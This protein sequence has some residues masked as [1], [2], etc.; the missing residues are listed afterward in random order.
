MKVKCIPVWT[1]VIW[2]CI[3]VFNDPVRRQSACKTTFYQQPSANTPAVLYFSK[4]SCLYLRWN[5]EISGE[6]LDNCGTQLTTFAANGQTDGKWTTTQVPQETTKEKKVSHWAPD[7][8]C[9]H[10]ARTQIQWASCLWPGRAVVGREYLF[11]F[12][13]PTL[14][15]RSLRCSRGIPDFTDSNNSPYALLTC[16]TDCR[17]REQEESCG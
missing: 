10:N 11:W 9:T 1:I 13:F 3:S 4:L 8:K 14:L 15:C 5:W 17:K 6:T 7:H 12:F 2:L 16:W